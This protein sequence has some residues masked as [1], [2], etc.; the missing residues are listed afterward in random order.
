MQSFAFEPGCRLLIREDLL[1]PFRRYRLLSEVTIDGVAASGKSSV[2]SGVARAL[3]IPYVSS[4]LLYRAATLL[5]LEARLDLGEAAPLTLL[6]GMD[7]DQAEAVL[8][9]GQSSNPE[10][11]HF[12]D[13]TRLFSRSEWVNLPFTQPEIE[14]DPARTVVQLSE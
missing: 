8:T 11:P 14:A 13:Q 1:A 2:S 10:S 12:S 4:G 6:R 3:G 9:Y 5:G 7:R